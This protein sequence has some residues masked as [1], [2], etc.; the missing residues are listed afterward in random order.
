MQ[1]N[2]VPILTGSDVGGVWLIP[3]FSLHQEFHELADAGLTPLQILQATT[4]RPAE[5]LNRE[6]SMG[7]VEEGKNADLV[8]LNAN[9][10][11]SVSSLDGIAGVVLKGKY[12]SADALEKMKSEVAASYK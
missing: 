7:T 2:G 1:Q 4:L 8:L 6:T 9:P 12:F 3:G 11:L 5:F 10:T